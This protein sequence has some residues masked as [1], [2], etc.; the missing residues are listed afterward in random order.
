MAELK[1]K[2][3]DRNVEDFLNQI[4]DQKRR[5]DCF[6]ILELMK[7]AVQSEAS[8]WGESIVGFGHYHYKYASGREADWMLAGFSPR[9]QNLT[10]YIMSGFE[11]Y[12]SLMQRLGKFKTGKACLY[13]KQVEDIDLD[14]LK[15]LVVRSVEYIR[16]TFPD[17]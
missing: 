10:I 6:T 16:R 9:K 1:T 17:Q 5:Q 13:I 8:M 3:N 15:E 11:H 12:D 4:E 7:T 14:V 2:E